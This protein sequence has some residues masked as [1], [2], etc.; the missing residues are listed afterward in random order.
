MSD[1]AMSVVPAQVTPRWRLSTPQL[2][3]A[4]LRCVSVALV[5]A[6]WAAFSSANARYLKLFNVA[7]M[8]SPLDVLRTGVELV[9]SGE[10]QNDILASMSRVL[11]GFAI[12]ALAGVALGMAVG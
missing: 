7:L 10:L 5:F 3:R 9:Q 12:A 1:R 8:P 11:Q 2:R 6:V 4:L